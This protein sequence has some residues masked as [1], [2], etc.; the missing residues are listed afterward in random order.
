M[1][2]FDFSDE[3]RVLMSDRIDTLEHELAQAKARRDAYLN[4]IYG[5]TGRAWLDY[6]SHE[7]RE[8][9]GLHEYQ[10]QAIEGALLSSISAGSIETDEE[11]D[12]ISAICEEWGIPNV[13]DTWGADL[14][15]QM[16]QNRAVLG[17]DDPSATSPTFTN[18]RQ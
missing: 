10:K 9:L 2:P 5:I 8:K 13:F 7:E 15:M 3:A 12:E 16:A 11:A 1:K 4:I 14:Q 17:L 18:P 6:L